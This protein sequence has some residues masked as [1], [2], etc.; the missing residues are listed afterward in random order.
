MNKVKAIFAVIVIFGFIC[1]ILPSSSENDN[2]K[3]IEQ[4]SQKKTKQEI[5]NETEQQRFNKVAEDWDE[6][7]SIECYNG[8]C[9]VVYFNYNTLEDDIKTIIEMNT[10]LLSKRKKEQTGVSHVT[11]NAIYKGQIVYT[12]DG[13]KGKIDKC[14]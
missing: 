8:N 3:G 5:W 11:I 12:C 9:N 6:V 10:T 7:D 13:S 4:Q 14:R 1:I 2:N